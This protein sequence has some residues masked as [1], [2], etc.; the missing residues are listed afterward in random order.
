MQCIFPIRSSTYLIQSYPLLNTQPEEER[1]TANLRKKVSL[2]QNHYWNNSR[3]FITQRKYGKLSHSFELFCRFAK[4]LGLFPIVFDSSCHH[5]KIKWSD[6]LYSLMASMVPVC[7]IYFDWISNNLTATWL[8][9]LW[10]NHAMFGVLITIPL[11]INQFSKC[12]AIAKYF[13]AVNEF[14]K[15]VK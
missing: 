6:L 3:T 9:Q 7:F 14:D 13:K 11:F 4:L 1:M 2:F 5:F 15:K 12:W 10:R 8:K